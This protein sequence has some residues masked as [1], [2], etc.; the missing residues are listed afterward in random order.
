M[1]EVELRQ[2]LCPMTFGSG[3]LRDRNCVGKHCAACSTYLEHESKPVG[4]D[5]PEPWKKH[6]H[7]TGEGGAVTHRQTWVREH[8]F[9]TLYPGTRRNER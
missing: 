4:M 6:G 1:I 8:V 3:T 2:L 9:C 7:R 5:M